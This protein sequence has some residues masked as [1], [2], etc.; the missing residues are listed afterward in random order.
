MIALT[1]DYIVFWRRELSTYQHN[2][3]TQDA[4]PWVLA[5]WVW[6]QG[7]MSRAVIGRPPPVLACDWLIL[8]A[9][10]LVQSV[11]GPQSK[12]GDIAP[13]MTEVELY[14]INQIFYL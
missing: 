8:P 3:Q 7:C 14:R 9:R 11:R 6:Y 13:V 1:E 12:G 10:Q 5:T 2:N 4:N